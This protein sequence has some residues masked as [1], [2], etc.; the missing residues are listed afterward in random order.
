MLPWCGISGIR[1]TFFL[2]AI[3]VPTVCKLA[4]VNPLASLGPHSYNLANRNAPTLAMYGGSKCA[5]NPLFDSWNVER[6]IPLLNAAIAAI[7]LRFL[8]D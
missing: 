8:S 5:R 2:R 1:D 4:D 7:R 3:V 6:E